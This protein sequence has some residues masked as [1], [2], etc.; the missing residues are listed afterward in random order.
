MKSK[1]SEQ[2]FDTPPN[3]DTPECE[4]S[5]HCDLCKNPIGEWGIINIQKLETT[6]Q[7]T[8]LCS[9]KCKLKYKHD[10]ICEYCHKEFSVYKRSSK[11]ARFC[12]RKCFYDSTKQRCGL[13]QVCGKQIEGFDRNKQQLKKCCSQK[14]AAK[15]RSWRYKTHYFC[16]INNHWVKIEDAIKLSAKHYTCPKFGHENNRLRISSRKAKLNQIRDNVKR[17]E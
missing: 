10:R 7:I 4:T 13:C 1:M 8:F 17:I 15:M 6:K 12:S 3:D 2:T 14:C 9:T 11:E 16:D 5:L